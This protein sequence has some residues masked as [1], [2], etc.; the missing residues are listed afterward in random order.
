MSYLENKNVKNMMKK[1]NV[2][3]NKYSFYIDMT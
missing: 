1:N 2:Y 3:E